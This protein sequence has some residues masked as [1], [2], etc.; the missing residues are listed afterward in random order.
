MST[1][2][3]FRRVWDGIWHGPADLRRTITEAYAGDFRQ[4]ISSLPEPVGRAQWIEFVAGWRQAYPDGRM[5]IDDL[6]TQGDKVWCYW[7]ST[8]T[9]SASYLGVPATG[10]QVRYQGVDIW[11]FDADGKVAETWAV[12]DVL[13]LLKQLGAIP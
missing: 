10:K 13:T 11:R 8:G 2:T 1:E 12:P 5:A 3:T 9:H 7:T 4:Y 6:V